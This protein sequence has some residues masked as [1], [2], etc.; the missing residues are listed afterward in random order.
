MS[1]GFP[2][3]AAAL[4]ER[5]LEIETKS[6]GTNHPSTATTMNN[7]AVLYKKLG[8]YGRAIPYLVIPL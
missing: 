8:R 6:L 2:E 5:C 3:E 7:L 4:C 1:I